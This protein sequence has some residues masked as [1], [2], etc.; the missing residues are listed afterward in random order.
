[1]WG[2]SYVSPD[3]HDAIADLES[4]TQP[5]GHALPGRARDPDA[6]AHDGGPVGRLPIQ[7]PAALGIGPGLE[8]RLR[9]RAGLVTDRDVGHRTGLLGVATEDRAAGDGRAL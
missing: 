6:V 5:D 1:R 3:G 7:H 4:V 8:V 2:R 9:Q